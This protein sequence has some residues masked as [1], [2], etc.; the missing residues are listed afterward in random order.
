[1]TTMRKVTIAV[2]L[3]AAA[4]VGV[5]VIDIFVGPR[6]FLGGFDRGMQARYERISEGE[7]KKLVVDSLGEPLAKSD[8]FNLPQRHGFEHFFDA[9]KKSPAVE[10][11]LWV[12]GSNW[13]YSIGFDSTGR[14]VI[15]GEGNS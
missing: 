2:M 11:Y 5:A 3:A 8:E 4:Q 1:M 13:F 6:G 14:V 9:A 7:S 10:Y 15:K 12:N